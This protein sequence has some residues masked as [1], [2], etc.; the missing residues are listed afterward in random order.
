M[1]GEGEGS[2][3][4]D[5]GPSQN[6]DARNHEQDDDATGTPRACLTRCDCIQSGTQRSRGRSAE[7][8]PSC[9]TQAPRRRPVNPM[10]E[11]GG[12]KSIAKGP[13]NIRQGDGTETTSQGPGPTDARKQGD[14]TD[15][16]SQG[17]GQ[18]R[19][20]REE[21]DENLGRNPRRSEG[22]PGERW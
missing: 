11:R 14:D 21:D 22:K 2:K 6:A 9:P 16:T 7:D 3:K 4:T 1:G 10:A 8:R 12:V 15:T 5:A 20:M 13:L 18:G 17:P 19:K